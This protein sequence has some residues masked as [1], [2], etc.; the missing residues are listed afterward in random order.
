MALPNDG[1][2]HIQ[3]GKG[4]GSYKDK[5]TFK[6]GERNRANLYY[7]SVNIGPGYKKRF[8]SPRGKIIAREFGT[9]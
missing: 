5:Y 8:V 9:Y 2:Y 3:V 6:P 7:N 4:T 1:K